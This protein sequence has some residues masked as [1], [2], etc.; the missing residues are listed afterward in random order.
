MQT[1]A[2]GGENRGRTRGVR[3]SSGGDGGIDRG[4]GA[5]RCVY[6][7]SAV[8]GS[9]DVLT[10]LFSGSVIKALSHSWTGHASHLTQNCFQFSDFANR[11]PSCLRGADGVEL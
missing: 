1:R 11:I 7:V 3:S 8:V 2:A 5:V 4:R 6:V 9:E 10:T